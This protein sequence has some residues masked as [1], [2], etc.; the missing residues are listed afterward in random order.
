VFKYYFIFP[1]FL[2]GSLLVIYMSK[3]MLLPFYFRCLSVLSL[4]LFTGFEM[5]GHL[6][7]IKKSK[8]RLNT[9]LVL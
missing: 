5:N 6:L 4:L 2:T 1:L 8:F 3:E 7:V 9:L